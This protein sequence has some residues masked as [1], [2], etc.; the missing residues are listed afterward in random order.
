MVHQHASAAA[1]LLTHLVA[2]P[3]CAVLIAG[4]TSLYEVITSVLAVVR[5]LVAEP[6]ARPHK[7]GLPPSPQL[8]PLVGV[9]APG[10]IGVRGPPAN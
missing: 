4:G 2:I 8:R 7:A 6:V 1:M 9:F 5:R 3:L 10:G